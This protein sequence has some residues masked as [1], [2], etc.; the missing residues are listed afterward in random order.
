[1]K[2][3]RLFALVIISSFSLSACEMFEEMFVTDNELIHDTHYEPI[4]GKFVLHETLDKRFTYTDTY[5]EIDG[6]KGV[7]SL[8]YY[9]NGKLKRDAKIARLV[10]R[11]EALGKWSDALHFNIK[12]GKVNE[13]IS[14]YTESL[15]PINQFRI[16]QEYYNPGDALYYLSELPYVMGTYVRVGQDYQ[17]EQHN[18]NQRDY[19]TPTDNNFT[20]AVDGTYKLDEN[21]YF[22]FLNP[23]GWTAADGSF[24]NSFFQYYSSELDKP[25][26]G[27][28]NGFSTE[29]FDGVVRK[30]LFMTTSRDSINWGQ[31]GSRT[32]HFYYNT[33][34][35]NDEML[36]HFGTIDYADGVMNSFTFEHL[37]R[38]WSDAEWAPYLSGEVNELPDNILY[39]FVGGTYTKVQ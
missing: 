16:I 37:T 5:F 14:A 1:M 24:I 26:E 28:V 21:H 19:M 31:D 23:H 27:F 35:P 30:R 11:K 2:K 12:N 4:T 25:I 33:F 34:P 20:V 7:F 8:K 32:I 3:L 15:D 13:H 36:F 38:E 18:T 22:Y 29:D 10:T 17:E 39:D 6:G 9:E